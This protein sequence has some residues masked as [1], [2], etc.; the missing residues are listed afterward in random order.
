M[1]D[2]LYRARKA[3]WKKNHDAFDLKFPGGIRGLEEE[4]CLLLLSEF[5][6]IL[7]QT[8]GTIAQNYPRL[9][10]EVDDDEAQGQDIETILERASTSLFKITKVTH[11]VHQALVDWMFCGIGWV[12]TDL[13]PPG[14]DIIAP[15][16]A[17][18]PQAEDLVSFST[19]RPWNVHVDPQITYTL[20]EARY[21]RERMVIPTEQLEKDPNVTK[22]KEGWPTSG[23]VPDTEIGFG[24]NM[25]EGKSDAEADAIKASLKNGDFQ[26]V[27]RIHWRTERKLVMFV[28]GVREPI[29]EMPHPMAR[30]EFSQKLGI[31]VNRETGVLGDQEP[32]FERNEE[33]GEETDTPT[34]DM[35]HEGEDGHPGD[36]VTGWLVQHGFPLTPVRLDLH[37]TSFYPTPLLTYVRDPQEAVV[38][39]MSRAAALQK[40]F[41]RQILVNDQEEDAH[42]EAI[43]NIQLG[44]DGSGHYVNNHANYDVIDWGGNPQ[45]FSEL[46]DALLMFIE[47]VTRVN[48][49]TGDDTDITATQAALVGA[50][51]SVNEKWLEAG[52]SNVYVELDRNALTIFGDARYTPEAFIVNVAA[53]GQ[54]QLSRALKQSD[55]LWN[56]EI[57]AIAKSMQPLFAQFQEERETSLYD[58]GRQNELIDQRELTKRYITSIAEGDPEKLMITEENQEALQLVQFENNYMVSRGEDPGV[59]PDFD[60]Q[61]HLEGHPQYKSHPDY[62]ELQQLAQQTSAIDG[63]TPIRPDAVQQIQVIDQVMDQHAQAHEQALEEQQAGGGGGATPS[64]GAGPRDLQAQVASNAQTT[65]AAVGANVAEEALS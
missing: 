25:D 65:K 63:V 42:P 9:L 54:Q 51:A 55:F 64:A 53:E 27:D 8:I 49:L 57:V 60:H 41:S 21:I 28:D 58:R 48:E 24:Q 37:P 19:R 15:W 32:M 13:N 12:G 14:D 4:D 30:R 61:V 20:D 35:E 34:L 2:T 40:R 56:F 5:F 16:V 6:P 17:N 44:V 43:P 22:P 50:A 36:P 23:S 59:Q 47:R 18:D 10:F 38:E 62:Q 45:G 39:L 46:L 31:G 1:L 29:M 52:V 33:T 26:T 7:R 11:H 3:E